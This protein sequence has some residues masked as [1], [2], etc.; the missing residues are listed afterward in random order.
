MVFADELEEGAHNH[1]PSIDG[2]GR[3]SESFSQLTRAR[4]ENNVNSNLFITVNIKAI[5]TKPYFLVA[6]YCEIS[7]ISFTPKKIEN[8]MIGIQII[9]VSRVP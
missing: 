6:F 1:L 5:I 2:A 4:T 9:T 7:N 8:T 3:G